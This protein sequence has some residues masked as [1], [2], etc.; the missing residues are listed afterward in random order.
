MQGQH[1]KGECISTYQQQLN[2]EFFEYNIITASKNIKYHEPKL[3]K[4]SVSYIINYFTEQEERS[5]N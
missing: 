3:F 5:S 1:A 2:G 4:A